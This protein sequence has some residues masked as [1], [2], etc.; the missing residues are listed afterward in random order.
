MRS[1]AR[2]SSA[3]A[4][5]A[6]PRPA[7]SRSARSDAG[8]L[9][10]L[11]DA[12]IEPGESTPMNISGGSARKCRDQPRA[13]AAQFAVAAEYLSQPRTDNLLHAA[14]GCGSPRLPSPRR[15]RPRCERPADALLRARH[16]ACAQQ[17]AR[18]FAGDDA[19]AHRRAPL[20]PPAR[21][22]GGPCRR[23]GSFRQGGSA[24]DAAPGIPDE[25]GEC[26]TSGNWRRRPRSSRSR[27]RAGVRPER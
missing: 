26:A 7:G 11:L 19:D 21:G 4:S 25:L 5:C 18:G 15:R 8:A 22:G 27:P 23:P 6:R 13:H 24:D 17:V 16:Q 1:T 3:P 20:A 12:E 10:Q 9:E 14:T 2:G